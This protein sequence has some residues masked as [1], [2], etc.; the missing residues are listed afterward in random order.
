MPDPARTS[1]V[2]VVL[3]VKGLGMV[4]PRF[5]LE[6][7]AK[8]DEKGWKPRR[9][10]RGEQTSSTTLHYENPAGTIYLAGLDQSPSW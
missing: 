7:K 5:S 1:V 9:L 2:F 4:G 6:G 10:N 3:L 8:S